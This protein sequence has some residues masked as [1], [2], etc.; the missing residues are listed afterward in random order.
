[1]ARAMLKGIGKDLSLPPKQT[2]LRLLDIPEICLVAAI[3]IAVKHFLPFTT[4]A[5]NAL[6]L[7]DTVLP[8]MDWQRWSELMMPVVESLPRK[9]P[10]DLP[11]D[12]DG[13]RLANVDGATFDTILAL[14]SSSREEDG[15]HKGKR[16][17]S[18]AR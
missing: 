16:N 15:G 3:V 2:R 14:L 17:D 18:D 10:A 4:G 13:D 12:I 9:A 1:M 7:Q 5:E 8:Q 6:V 11:N